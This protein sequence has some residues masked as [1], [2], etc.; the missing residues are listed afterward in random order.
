M[1]IQELLPWIEL[2]LKWGVPA[3]SDAIAKIKAGGN[4]DPTPEQ[5]QAIM[6][7]VAPPV[8]YSV[9]NG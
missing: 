1:K 4:D 5:V 2:V 7:G 3:V 9:D 6:E 8:D